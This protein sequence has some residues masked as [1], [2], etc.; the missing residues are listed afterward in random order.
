[1]KETRVDQII[2]RLGLQASSR[3]LGEALRL[4][5][6]LQG[7]R[8]IVHDISC[9]ARVYDSPKCD[10]SVARVKAFLWSLEP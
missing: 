9:R 1:M 4:L 2:L 7:R 10:C 8:M 5:Y 3:M 6:D